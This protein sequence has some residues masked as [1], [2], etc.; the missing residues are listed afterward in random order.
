MNLQ[1][2]L[3]GDSFFQAANGKAV[4]FIGNIAG[5]PKEHGGVLISEDGHTFF[6]TRLVK[7]VGV[8]H[9]AT[10]VI[11]DAIENQLHIFK[12][13]MTWEKDGPFETACVNTVISN[14]LSYTRQQ[15]PAVIEVVEVPEDRFLLSANLLRAGSFTA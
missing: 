11:F 1:N 14:D 8:G 12:K 13:V 9:E 3:L 7:T 6:E 15:P 4:I 5:V 10:V 2:G